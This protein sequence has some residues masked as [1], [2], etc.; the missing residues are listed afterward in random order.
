MAITPIG[1]LFFGSVIFGILLMAGVSRRWTLDGKPTGIG[2]NLFFG[3]VLVIMSN[4]LFM[5][6]FIGGQA[7]YGMIM[8]PKYEAT[9]ISFDSTRERV[10][11]RDSDGDNY[12]ENVLMHTPTLRFADNTGRIITQKGNVRSGAEPIVG[13]KVTVAYRT[14]DPLQVI[15]IASIG[16]YI[17][18]AVMLLILGYILTQILFFVLGRKSKRLDKIG[19]ILLFYVVIGGGMLGM[20]AGMIY[21]VYSYFQP[22]SDMPL[23]IML[24]CVFYIMPIF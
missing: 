5:L 17:G 22:G 20:L 11:R 3:L 12:T 9:I 23:S 15:S 7:V 4:L 16:L 14:G 8:L 6:T 21:G 2:T 18:L 24:V 13:N 19:G 10:T 1:Y